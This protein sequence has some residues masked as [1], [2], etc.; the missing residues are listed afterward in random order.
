MTPS[1]RLGHP[2]Y[3]HV[4]D[5]S[6][7]PTLQSHVPD[8]FCVRPPILSQVPGFHVPLTSIVGQIDRFGVPGDFHV[9]DLDFLARA[10]V[11]IEKPD[12]DA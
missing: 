11:A 10:R 7:C 9:P 4:P 12:T 3:F 1:A 5:P 6:M 2:P 8:P